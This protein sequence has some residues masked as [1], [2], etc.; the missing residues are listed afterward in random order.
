MHLVALSPPRSTLAD[1]AV[2]VVFSVPAIVMATDY[3]AA[4]EEAA[5]LS[6]DPFPCDNTCEMVL[7]IRSL[8]TALIYFRDCDRR[9]ELLDFR[10]LCRKV[11]H[12]L[13]ADA[14]VCAGTATGGRAVARGTGDGYRLQFNQDPD[15]VQEFTTG[16]FAESSVASEGAGPLHSIHGDHTDDF[17]VVEDPKADTGARIAYQLMDDDAPGV[18]DAL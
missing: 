12:R 9:N 6:A 18:A 11:W 5:Y 13:K 3:C 17:C 10:V 2:F 1:I 14:R 8:A 15:D 16:S 7:S 4:N